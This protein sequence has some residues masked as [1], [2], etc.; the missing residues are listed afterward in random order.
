MA[1]LGTLAATGVF[2]PGDV[3]NEAELLNNAT[4]TLGRLIF[5]HIEL[6]PEDFLA[7][8]NS[9]VEDERE[10]WGRANS[11]TY[12][13]DFADNAARDQVLALE[14]RYSALFE[15]VNGVISGRLAAEETSTIDPFSDPD[16]RKPQELFPIVKGEAKSILED[17]RS[18]GWEVI[19]AGAVVLALGVTAAVIL[20]KSAGVKVAL[21]GGSVG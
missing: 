1:E 7:G 2:T 12:W 8:W 3:K 11:F 18:I 20:V 10:F 9:Y 14:R 5:N 16:E 4:R 21:P 13:I 15:K 17:I 19:L 6:F